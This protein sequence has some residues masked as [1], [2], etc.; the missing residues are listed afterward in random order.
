MLPV[1]ALPRPVFRAPALS[2]A[3]SHSGLEHEWSLY[4]DPSPLLPPPGPR[5]PS[6]PPVTAPA[7]SP[8]TAYYTF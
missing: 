3:S 4:R 5:A 8:F 6:W 7:L 2:L 1:V